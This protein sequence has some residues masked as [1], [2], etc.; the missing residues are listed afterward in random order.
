MRSGWQDTVIMSLH[1]WNVID[2]RTHHLAD[3]RQYTYWDLDGVRQS[4]W[5]LVHLEASNPGVHNLA[6][7]VGYAAALGKRI[8]LVDGADASLKRYT[9][10][11]RGCADITLATLD[12]AITFLQK[13]SA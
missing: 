2:P 3:E 9:G 13:L 8:I 4:D 11:L 1:R 7:E 6:V 5:V 10:M 12:E